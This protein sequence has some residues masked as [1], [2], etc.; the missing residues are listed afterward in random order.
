MKQTKL[1]KKIRNSWLWLRSIYQQA[2]FLHIEKTV[3]IIEI[4]RSFL[5]RIF[6]VIVSL[7]FEFAFA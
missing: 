5:N 7:E 6:L 2:F 4:R 3:L 1:C